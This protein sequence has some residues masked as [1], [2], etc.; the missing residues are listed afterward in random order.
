M[1][2]DQTAVDKERIVAIG[3]LSDVH[4]RM[5]GSS[6]KQVFLISEDDQFDALIRALDEMEATRGSGSTH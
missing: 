6:L 2:K 4:L 1:A 3:L 5:L